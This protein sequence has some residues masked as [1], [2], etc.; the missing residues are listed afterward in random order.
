MS[1]LDMLVSGGYAGNGEEVE[2]DITKG[3]KDVLWM[4]GTVVHVEFCGVVG[5]DDK[6]E[7][8]QELARERGLGSLVLR[9]EDSFDPNLGERIGWTFGSGNGWDTGRHQGSRYVAWPDR[10]ENL[11]L[12]LHSASTSSYSSRIITLPPI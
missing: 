6:M 1:M 2:V 3:K 11:D 10:P 7:A 5:G 4:K 8:I 9:A 12:P